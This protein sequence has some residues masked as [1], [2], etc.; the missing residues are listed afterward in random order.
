MTSK[1]KEKPK[2]LH[3]ILISK[4]TGVMIPKTITTPIFL[5]SYRK[6]D[7]VLVQVARFKEFEI[8]IYA[9]KDERDAVLDR[10]D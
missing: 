9:D 2:M 7:G 5:R 10:L 1:R 8:E 6:I 3:A 4:E